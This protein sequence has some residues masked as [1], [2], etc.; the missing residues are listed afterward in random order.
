MDHPAALVAL[1]NDA[2]EYEV[3]SAA[4]L[5][6]SPDEMKAFAV[7]VDKS[8]KA[9]EVLAAVKRVFGNDVNAYQQIYLSPRIV[10]RKL[11][12][13]F[14]HNAEMHQLQRDSIQ[15][16]WALVH[17]DNGFEQA[18]KTA[19]L[20]YKVLEYGGKP[21]AAP[22]AVKSYF[23]EGIATIS[24]SFRKLLD[25]TKAGTIVSTIAENDHSYRIVRLVDKKD[26]IYNAEEI[27]AAKASFDL[28]FK[29]QAGKVNVQIHDAA[30]KQSIR[31]T[32]ANITWVKQL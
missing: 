11:R 6:P 13:W 8:T 7:H 5:T 17:A 28:W 29:Q 32:Y 25:A 23:P 21:N 24:E 18:A 14:S 15:Q 30:L 4:D 31:T 22:N 20:S 26:G 9:P 27:S 16:A 12:S 10:N 3:A 2:V 1:I 19:G